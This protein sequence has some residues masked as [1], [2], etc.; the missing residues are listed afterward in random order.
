MNRG[1]KSRPI[2]FIILALIIITGTISAK[3]CE[4]KIF[5]GKTKVDL[6]PVRSFF[7]TADLRILP[8]EKSVKLS[9]SIVLMKKKDFKKSKITS[10]GEGKL[11]IYLSEDI[12]S[13]QNDSQVFSDLIASAI[14]KKSG[15]SSG[16]NYNNL[17]KWLSHAILNKILRRNSGNIIPGTILFPGIHALVLSREKTDWINVITNPMRPE[18]GKAYLIYLETSEI[19]LDAI[20]R[21]PEG[22]K[23]IMDIIELSNKEIGGEDLF[24]GVMLKKIQDVQKK[25][26]NLTFGE[27]TESDIVDD[28]LNY[29]VKLSSV[30]VLNPC[31]ATFAERLFK[32][33]ELI[34]YLTKKGK[35]DNSPQ[36]ERYCK[37]EELPEKMDEIDDLNSV[38]FKKQRDLVRIAFSMPIPLQK[39]IY[40]IEKSLKLILSGDK[41]EFLKRYNGRKLV[42]YDKLEKQHQ[43]ESYMLKMEKALVSP[44]Y[45]FSS[46]LSI[47]KKHDRDKRKRW[48]E[49][50]EFLDNIEK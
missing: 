19:I 45:R 50:T 26:K 5:T 25:V 38:I 37:I 3:N 29:N 23:A 40:Q 12:K 1:I 31:D 8:K 7:K 43:I 22:K 33:A 13:W 32:K 39:P 35:N 16:E 20:I 27:G 30:N 34:Q 41:E 28:W 18:D 4:I 46:E 14:L 15:T 9:Y 36:E 21:F 10:D 2:I 47:L 17:P 42:F 6:E 49:L 11:R 24:R 44:G 48:P